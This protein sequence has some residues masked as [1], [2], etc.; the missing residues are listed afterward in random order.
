[1]E[2]I[3]SNIWILMAFWIG[4]TLGFVVFALMQVAREGCEKE[5]RAMR[6][7]RAAAP[8]FRSGSPVGRIAAR[9]KSPSHVG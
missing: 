4:A 8:K 7:M 3:M 6:R 2:D 5:D 9:A 1:L